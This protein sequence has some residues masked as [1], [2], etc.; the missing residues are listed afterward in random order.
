M[1]LQAWC[2]LCQSANHF[3]GFGYGES[4]QHSAASTAKSKSQQKPG[5]PRFCSGEKV[6]FL[7]RLGFLKLWHPVRSAPGRA[8]LSP[9]VPAE[10]VDADSSTPATSSRL[11]PFAKTLGRSWKQW[12]G[13]PFWKSRVAPFE[14][15]KAS[16]GCAGREGW[17]GQLYSSNFQQ[18]RVFSEASAEARRKR[19]VSKKWKKCKK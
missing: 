14:E 6:S 9:A 8:K 17:C 19:K 16:S 4:T 7:S 2:L 10:T 3:S 11:E 5:L 1:A 15:S 13:C 12:K 18:A